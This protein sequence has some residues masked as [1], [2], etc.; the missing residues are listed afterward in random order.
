[1]KIIYMGT[2]DFAVAPLEAI[3]K[4]GH[5]VTA[6]VTQ[7]D[8]QK[9][10]GREVQY[11]PV[12]ECAL[13]YGIP[14][15]QPLKIKEKDA[16][17]ELRKYPADIFV[18]AAFGQLLSEE[19]L[20]MPRLGC[21]NIHASLLPA[22]RGAAPIQWCVINGEEKTM[23]MI[24]ALSKYLRLSLSK[25]REIVTVEDE[26]ENVK[27]YMEIQQI[28][29]ENLFR[30]EIECA[31]E[32]KTRWILKLILQP[33]VENAVKYGF[34][35]IFEGGLIRISVTEQAGQL[36]FSVYNNGTPMEEQM[37]EK[38]NGLSEIPV[39]KM[40]DSFE[41]KKH[42]YGVIN[43]ITRLRLKYGEDVRFFYES[44]T[45]GTVC[46]I[47]IPDDGKENSEQ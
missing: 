9:G 26:L 24:Q 15:L 5:E 13:S 22:Y 33:I 37:A 18:V 14:V 47:Q 31:E 25:G 35:D 23:K 20:N 39:S 8:R 4:A 3:L 32:L 30:Y 7:P 11:S 16:V 36:T 38:L 44:D 1:M 46:V 40:K 27:S 42:G 2:P 21:I 17:E 41:D 34:C 29:N 10:R 43:I 28:R 12:K 19:I 6:V 45:N